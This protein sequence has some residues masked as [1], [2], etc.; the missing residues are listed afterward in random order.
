MDF[1][2]NESAHMS[3]TSSSFWKWRRPKFTNNGEPTD[4]IPTGTASDALA[5]LFGDKELSDITLE[6]SDGGQVYA[7]K[8]VLAVR[9]SVFRQKFYGKNTKK[10]NTMLLPGEKEVCVF[11]DWDCRVLHLMVEYCYTDTCAAFSAAPTE[12]IARLI[13]HL[14]V[15][16]K[17]FRLP[18]LDAKIKQWGW[19]QISRHPALACALIDEGMRLDDIY[20]LALQTLQLKPRAALLPGIGAVGTG[21]LALSKPGLLFVLRTLEDSTSHLLLLQV[22]ER[23]ADFSSMDDEGNSPVR[24]KRVREAFGR[25]CALRFIKRDSN[26]PYRSALENAIKNSKLFQERTDLANSIS[27]LDGGIQFSQATKQRY[28]ESSSAENEAKSKPRPATAI[29]LVRA[30]DPKAPETISPS[31]SQ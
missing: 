10:N 11:N 3:G 1:P 29:G 7:V 23:W 8:A 5:T 13:A 26:N 17:T 30:S 27:L 14:L 20:E 4:T 9:S 2:V 21:V 18:G 6:G 12:E 24:E 15:A 19:R 28:I 22:I 31:V 25:K 16:A